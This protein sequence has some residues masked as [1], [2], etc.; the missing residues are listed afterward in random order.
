MTREEIMRLSGRELDAAVAEHVLGIDLYTINPHDGSNEY[1]VDAGSDG[2]IQAFRPLPRYSTDM[3]E[4]WR[5]L[6]TFPGAIA[7]MNAVNGQ[8]QCV[9]LLTATGMTAPGAICR[10]QLVGVVRA[11]RQTQTK[12]IQGEARRA[13][14]I[15]PA[16]NQRPLVGPVNG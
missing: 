7:L 5:V 6:D 1:W 16:A 15:K 13:R 12:A 14:A 2:D 9:M 3:A 10:A 11:K 8:W 4:A